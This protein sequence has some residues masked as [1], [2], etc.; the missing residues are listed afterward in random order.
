[1]DD[2]FEDVPLGGIPN[3]TENGHSAE[4]DEKPSIQLNGTK[5]ESSEPSSLSEK[6]QK[7]FSIELE[8]VQC[9]ANPEYLKYLAQSRYLQDKAF[10]NYLEYLQY[11]KQPQYAKF[12][13][14]PHCLY[15]LEL[16]QEEAFRRELL[17][18]AFSVYI[19]Q[20]QFYHWMYYRNKRLVSAA[21]PVADTSMETEEMKAE[22]DYSM[23]AHFMFFGLFGVLF[24]FAVLSSVIFLNFATSETIMSTLL[25]GR[26]SII[27]TLRRLHSTERVRKHITFHL[28]GNKIDV[29]SNIKPTLMLSDYLRDHQHLT[30]TKLACQ[31]GACGSC[32]VSISSQDP[33]RKTIEHHP[34]VSCITPIALV[35]GKNITTVEGIGSTNDGLHPIQERM[36]AFGASQ[37]G[38]CTPGFVMSMYAGLRMQSNDTFE[39]FSE[40]FKGN[41]C[42]CTGY[43]SISDV[44]K[45]FCADTEATVRP[46][47]GQTFPAYRS[48][49]SE[50]FLGDIGGDGLVVDETS[51]HYFSPT[52][53]LDLARHKSDHPDAVVVGG[54]TS[55]VPSIYHGETAPMKWV[56]VSRIPELNR[57]EFGETS[58]CIGAGVTLA[59]IIRSIEAESSKKIHPRHRVVF[60]ESMKKQMSRIGSAQIRATGTLAGNILST[61]AASD[62]NP[63]LW[64]TGAK[65]K[66]SQSD[67]QGS[68]YSVISQERNIEDILHRGEISDVEFIELIEI[69]WP[70]PNDHVHVYK[71]SRRREGDTSIVNGGFRVTLND[72]DVIGD[73]AMVFGG[74]TSSLVRPEKSE[75]FLAGKKWSKETID[76]VIPLLVE[77]VKTGGVD[78]HGGIT[79][80]KQTLPASFLVKFFHRV[81]NRKNSRIDATESHPFDSRPV[82]GSHHYDVP[83]RGTSVGKPEPHRWAALQSTGEAKYI[84]DMKFHRQLYGYLVTSSHSCADILSID[85]SQAEAYP[86]VHAVYT[87]K[88]VPGSNLFGEIE[89]DEEIFASKEVKLLGQPIGAVIAESEDIAREASK[90]VEVK[91]REKKG[92]FSIEEAKKRDSIYPHPVQFHTGDADAT[93]ATSPTVIEGNMRMGGQEHWYLETQSCLALPNDDDIVLHISTQNAHA[94]QH[95]VATALGLPAHRVTV[96]VGHVGGAFGGKETRNCIIAAAASLAARKLRRPVRFVLPRPLDMQTTGG[97]HPYVGHYRVGFDSSGKILAAKVD[98]TANGGHS[99]DLSGAVLVKTLLQCDGAYSIPNFSGVA[100]PART[101]VASNTAFRGFGTVQGWLFTEQW[102]DH[103]AHV[104]K[105]A[106]HE[107][108]ERNIM[109][110]GETTFYGMKVPKQLRRSWDTC[111]NSSKF[112]ERLEEV[113]EFNSKNLHCKRGLSILPTKYGVGFTAM[114]LNQGS[115]LVLCYVDGSVLVT[116][117]GVEMGQGLFTK[118]SQVVATELGIPSES[119]HMSEMSTDKIANASTTSASMGSDL[120]GGAVHNACRELNE[121]F[122][123][124]RASHPNATFAEICEKAYADRVSLSSLG[125]FKSEHKGLDMKTGR[126]EA[127]GGSTISLKIPGDP[128]R[129][130]TIGTACTEVEIDTLTGDYKV[131][132]ADIVMDLGAPVNPNVDIGQIEGAF[133]Q[134]QGWVTIEELWWGD[135]ERSWITPG[136]LQNSG[137]GTYKIPTLDDV[138]SRWNVTLLK[139]DI[140]KSIEISP[141]HSAKAVS[142]P[143]FLLGA[144]VYFSLKDAIKA[145]RSSRGLDE[146]FQIDSP[147]TTERVRM[148][149]VDD[150]TTAVLGEGAASFRAKGSF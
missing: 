86:G 106:P 141:V 122:A 101:N 113:K 81:A 55:V 33:I 80:Y 102:M 138:P 45:S 79:E 62:M 6:Q 38:F 1:M 69:P 77:E 75:K 14:Y 94:A 64:V 91:Y 10:V 93:L 90:L 39:R 135:E 137:P 49:N 109:R 2:D 108:R 87:Y 100:K 133:T 82:V 128:W 53:L 136:K 61:Y 13:I 115:A 139:E 123:P 143:P 52:T 103:A 35:D 71:Q 25:K 27:T 112:L 114:Q 95:T 107:L 47:N 59:K 68:N 15:F 24:R 67:T 26:G 60:L 85:V 5:E 65:I 131:L 96:K 7:Q 72:D 104:L 20:Q 150:I 76:E 110:E 149:C 48:E 17:N 119:V 46:F 127:G 124:Y 117:G 144:S 105:M 54:A 120:Y 34:V 11:W 23:H 63:L 8:F 3:S 126:G 16:L 57:V 129:Y 40:N 142:E 21:L 28:N 70:S 130:F 50:K 97:R 125:F 116:I 121:R 140:E 44:G 145:A 58:I 78:T 118:I 134:G 83:I 31:E 132:R 37:C 89:K 12:I 146:Y 32:T 73:V 41:L 92:I 99:L 36:T 9:L 51:T 84:A 148:A 43:R 66:V 98:M 147:L 30:G 56:T 29:P 22:D 88:D 42:R 18:P 74:L 4:V 19:H 111:K